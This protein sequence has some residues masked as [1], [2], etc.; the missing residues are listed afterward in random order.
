MHG[1]SV[2]CHH[3]LH[4]S[5]GQP[6]RCLPEC[7]GYRLWA[8]MALL[9][10]RPSGEC[11]AAR[12]TPVP[13]DRPVR[14]VSVPVACKHSRLAMVACSLRHANDNCILVPA[15]VPHP[16]KQHVHCPHVLAQ[17]VT[18]DVML[19]R[20]YKPG[21]AKNHQIPQSWNRLRCH[22]PSSETWSS[23]PALGRH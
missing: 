10:A 3:C 14:V 2:L 6:V 18:I 7:P 20:A 17:A 22:I 8:G 12:L 21:R 16:A 23:S 9:E 4:R 15:P 1:C 13:P 19:A 5:A 11:P